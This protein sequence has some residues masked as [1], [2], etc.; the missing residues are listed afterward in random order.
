[1]LL[2]IGCKSDKSVVPVVGFADAFEDATIVQARD[3]FTD[4]LAKNGF[5][6][7]EK[8][9][10]IIYR[11]A[12][13]DIPAL[14]QIV[15]YFI[16]EKVDLMA[17]CTTLSTITALQKS[18]D[19]PVFMMVSPTP[20]RMNVIDPSGKEPI[21]LH[22]VAEDLAYIDTSFAFI[23]KFLKSKGR[24]LVVGMIYNQSEPQSVDAYERIK[25][26]ASKLDI[27]I[28]ALPLNNSGEA[29][30]VTQLLLS[31]NIDAFFANP[32]NAVFASFETILK[33]CTNKSVPIFTSE[34]GLVKRGALVAYG[35][36]IYKWGYQAGEQAAT[37]LKTGKT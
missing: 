31:K 23:P 35:A 33:N 27:T 8:T 21:N 19:I 10:Q 2:N 17:T 29:Q 13:G 6:E 26:M 22:G 14:T 20:E 15:N 37:F 24:N 34:S 7:K 32:D 25:A 1:M 3:G 28:E 16:S 4:A 11:N 12:Q 36:D 9:V 18:K 30:L 5:S